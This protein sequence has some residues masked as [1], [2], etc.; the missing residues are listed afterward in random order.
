MKHINASSQI[1]FEDLFNSLCGGSRITPCEEREIYSVLMGQGFLFVFMLALFGNV[2]NI[3]I[4]NSD[5]IRF[6]IAIR[7]LSTKLLMNSLAMLFLLPQALRFIKVWEPGSDTDHKYWDYFP[8]QIYFVNVF[9]FCAMWLTVLM[10]S[11]CY[12]HVIHPS[13]SKSICTKKN[14][15]RSYIVI[16]LAG[17]LIPIIY[18]LNRVAKL[19]KQCGKHHLVIESS[20]EDHVIVFEKIHTIANLLLAIVIPM[21]LLI[22]MTGA[23][24]WRLVI[25]KPDFPHTKH[26]SNEKR[27]V[28]RITLITTGLQLIAELPPVPVMLYASIAG[29]LAIN[30]TAVCIWHTI[31][32][33][34][35]LCNMSLSFF[36]Y[37]ALSKNF[38]KMVQSRLAEFAKCLLP[39][40]ISRNYGL[41]K[42]HLS[43]SV[44]INSKSQTL[45]RINN[46]NNANSVVPEGA[47]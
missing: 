39:Q 7:M 18:P 40:C 2:I 26:F 12:L 25:R 46:N 36:V 11:E 24:F 15:W 47:N 34:L 42:Y 14:L 35:G 22:F 38:R 23:I 3:A 6:Y 44:T 43:E 19:Q 9:G 13:Q 32:V 17:L 30:E 20:L 41:N 1:S 4:Y 28:T 45:L 10:T 29:P 33:F 37:L 8:Y 31:G 27:C 5:Q 16:G 21:S